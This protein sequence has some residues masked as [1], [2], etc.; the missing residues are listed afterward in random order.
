MDMVGH[1]RVRNN[2]NVELPRRREKLL[3]HALSEHGRRQRVDPFP[4][5]YREEN[6][7]V[8]VA[9]EMLEAW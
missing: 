1:Q 3:A 6:V 9:V 5:I 7:A 4:A 8:C 2:F